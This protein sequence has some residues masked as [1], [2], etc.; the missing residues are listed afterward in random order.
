MRSPQD[1]HRY[2]CTRIT[3]APVNHSAQRGYDPHL[4]QRPRA[5]QLGHLR[6]PANSTTSPDP[7]SSSS[8]L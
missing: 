4:M 5:P 3:I 8:L 6:T 1:L 2:R 7:S